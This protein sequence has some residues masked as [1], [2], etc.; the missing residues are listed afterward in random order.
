MPT[1]SQ[2]TIQIDIVEIKPNEF[3]ALLKNLKHPERVTY[4]KSCLQSFDTKQSETCIRCDISEQFSI[5][6]KEE[7]TDNPET[8]YY[9]TEVKSRATKQF[10]QLLNE[11]VHDLL[12]EIINKNSPAELIDLFQKL[13]ADD[14][15]LIIK[16]LE[17]KQKIACYSALH[18]AINASTTISDK[19]PWL[20][21]LREQLSEAQKKH[22]SEKPPFTFKLSVY[23]LD[24]STGAYISAKNIPILLKNLTLQEGF[25]YANAR[26]IAESTE[27][28][29]RCNIGPLEIRY[30]AE[31]TWYPS[32]IYE[33]PQIKDHAQAEFIKFHHHTLLDLFDSIA[34]KNNP[35]DI[36]NLFRILN[37]KQRNYPDLCYK[38]DQ[39]IQTDPKNLNHFV[40][41]LNNKPGYISEL[42]ILSIE[43]RLRCIELLNPTAKKTCFN[44][45]ASTVDFFFCSHDTIQHFIA[46]MTELNYANDNWLSDYQFYC[47]FFI[48]TMMY[49]NTPRIESNACQITQP[50]I[51]QIRSLTKK[52][53]QT[54]ANPVMVYV[55]K[56]C[57]LCQHLTQL[58][59]E[60]E[61]DGTAIIFPDTYNAIVIAFLN[62]IKE[63]L[64]HNFRFPELRRYS[65]IPPSANEIYAYEKCEKWPRYQEFMLAETLKTLT[66]VIP[67]ETKEHL[68]LYKMIFKIAIK[69]C[70]QSVLENV[71]YAAKQGEK[72]KELLNDEQIRQSIQDV[73]EAHPFKTLLVSHKPAITKE[74]VYMNENI[75]N[76]SLK[77]IPRAEMS[78]FIL[79]VI[80]AEKTQGVKFYSFMEKQQPNP[81]DPCWIEQ[82]LKPKL[83]LDLNSLF[84]SPDGEGHFSYE[85]IREML[86]GP[87]KENFNWQQQQML[88]AALKKYDDDSKKNWAFYCDL[89]ARCPEI[90]NQVALLEQKPWKP[91]AEKTAEDPSETTRKLMAAEIKV[92]LSSMQEFFEELTRGKSQLAKNLLTVFCRHDVPTSPLLSSLKGFALLWPDLQKKMLAHVKK[93]IPIA[94]PDLV[95]TLWLN[96]NWDDESLDESLCNR[97]IE[98][99]IDTDDIFQSLINNSTLHNPLRH[100]SENNFNLF[101]QAFKIDKNSP[102]WSKLKYFLLNNPHSLDPAILSQFITADEINTLLRTKNPEHLYFLYHCSE[103][104]ITV[105][106]AHINIPNIIEHLRNIMPRYA[107]PDMWLFFLSRIKSK[108]SQDKFCQSFFSPEG[109]ISEKTNTVFNMIILYPDTR[110]FEHFILPIL[111]ELFTY[112]GL[113]TIWPKTHGEELTSATINVFQQ[114]ESYPDELEDSFFWDF[115]CIRIRLAMLLTIMSHTSPQI[116]AEVLEF[117]LSNSTLPYKDK[118]NPIKMLKKPTEKVKD[119]AKMMA[120]VMKGQMHHSPSGLI[121]TEKA[122]LYPASPEGNIRE[123]K[124]FEILE[125]AAPKR[126]ELK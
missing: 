37:R 28:F 30:T 75:R 118:Q 26:L 93:C 115:A 19:L 15:L 17:P 33:H 42:S 111:R 91:L 84:R 21:T 7:S 90:F 95:K 65:A 107:E 67:L 31:S 100:M 39:Y 46:I 38:V 2:L 14:R 123:T 4:I 40:E 57:N 88:A 58:A 119:L 24:E 72:I 20:E 44:I 81:N 54:E 126:T 83:G 50:W 109:A 23:T 125:A 9:S 73:L 34:Q 78:F 106:M 10:Q 69:Y 117:M 82:L 110:S 122:L 55:F 116:L 64:Q 121:T 43:S 71:L 32:Q 16:L 3:F 51:E 97:L 49:I 22:I 36:I 8:T 66:K 104:T 98:L 96:R 89:Y 76:I 113:K 62:N 5:I 61:G 52:P 27:E 35:N 1:H 112:P 45:I 29:I 103:A 53:S 99:E 41:Y 120:T 56:L 102:K 101:L 48:R 108:E 114:R 63:I 59:Q 6:Y 92:C 74:K 86:E 25:N 79:L 87:S 68:D 80:L 70:M 94:H 18:R 105:L 60:K 77:P 85:K 11:T 47:D 124:L 12:F 13:P